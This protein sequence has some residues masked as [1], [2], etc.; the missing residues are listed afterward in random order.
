M[1]GKALDILT[2]ITRAMELQREASKLLSSG[3][4]SWYFERIRDYIDG[5]FARSPFQPGD[6][7]VLVVAP[8]LD[9]GHG[10]YHCRHFLIV[11]AIGTVQTIDYTQGRFSADVVFEKETYKDSNGVE[12]P[13]AC[14]H[15]YAFDERS[16]RRIEETR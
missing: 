11:G 8:M 10:W 5:L 16:L 15:T 1:S 9:S 7:V 14:Q 3:P 4:S 2:R 12:H 6:R 13:V